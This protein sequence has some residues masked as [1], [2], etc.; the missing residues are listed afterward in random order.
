MCASVCFCLSYRSLTIACK[1]KDYKYDN[2]HC[3]EECCLLGIGLFYFNIQYKT[4]GECQKCNSEYP[5]GYTC[6][7]KGRKKEE[8]RNNDS[9]NRN[10]YTA[11]G[12]HHLAGVFVGQGVEICKSCRSA[13]YKEAVTSTSN[14]P[15]KPN[16]NAIKQGVTPKLI[17]SQRLSS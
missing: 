4:E 17:T 14:Q 8:Q 6:G 13:Y 16:E 11:E 15:S 12:F 10:R 2:L 7:N 9:G 1:E 5:H 3:Y